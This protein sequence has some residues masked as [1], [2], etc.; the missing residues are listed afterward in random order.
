MPRLR[1]HLTSTAA[2]PRPDTTDYHSLAAKTGTSPRQRGWR[3][4]ILLTASLLVGAFG[5]T[6]PAHASSGTPIVSWGA[7]DNNCLDAGGGWVSTWPCNGNANQRFTSYAVGTGGAWEARSD[8]GLCLDAGTSSGLGSCNPSRHSQWFIATTYGNGTSSVAVHPDGAP[9]FC[10][11][12]GFSHQWLLIA[13]CNGN[14][15][16][17]WY[18]G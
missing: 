6:A 16:Q 10:W 12:A 11:D 4:L 8:N 2:K 13:P 9:N 17:Q 7:K 3:R 15:N 14:I 1:N 5:I 18:M